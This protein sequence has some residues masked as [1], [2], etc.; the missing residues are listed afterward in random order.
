MAAK[1]GTTLNPSVDGPHRGAAQLFPFLFLRVRHTR[2]A[3][4]MVSKTWRLDITTTLCYKRVKEE[5]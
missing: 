4:Q 2:S 5:A 1:N 3:A